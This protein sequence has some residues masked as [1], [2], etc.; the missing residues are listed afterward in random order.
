MSTD[1]HRLE[2]V[3]NFFDD[4]TSVLL[5]QGQAEICIEGNSYVGKGEV[6]LDLL[7]RA[8][9]HLYGYFS[10]VPDSDVIGTRIGQKEISAFLINNHRIEGFML[11]SKVYETAHQYKYNVKWNPKSEPVTGVGDDST[12]MTRVIFHLFNFVDL[13]GTR[14]STE[15]NGTEVYAIEHVD[16]DCDEWNVELKSLISTRENIERL[17]QE[18]GYRLTHIGEIHKADQ[19]SFTGKDADGCLNMLRFF[20]SFAKGGWCEPICAVGFDAFGNRVWESWSSPTEPWRVLLSWFDPHNGSQLTTLFPGF[21]KRW[22]NDDWQGAM[23]EVIYW[24]LGANDSFHGIDTGIILTQAALERLSYEYSVRDKRLLAVEG[25]KNL[26]ASDRLR[27]LF[28]SLRIPLDIPA[29]TPTLRYFAISGQMKWWDAS[30]ALTEI[31]NSLVHPEHKHRSCFRNAYYEAWNLGLWY[32]EMGILAICDYSGTYGNR[33]KQR[34]V[35]QTE[36][37]PWKE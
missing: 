5:Y 15:Q 6:R 37:V 30:H 14:R 28:S 11:G 3:F 26:R 21:I 17:K 33:L 27:L 36:D 18:G 24:Y 25:F 29:E 10:G 19:T 32:L 34:W 23:R 8:N 22:A 35:G 4:E 1:T 16:L 13:L 20:L 31:R 12:Q 7:P 2:P 9:I